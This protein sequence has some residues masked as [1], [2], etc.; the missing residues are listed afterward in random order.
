MVTTLSA[1]SFDA[2]QARVDEYLNVVADARVGGALTAITGNIVTLDSSF[3]SVGI[4]LTANLFEANIA[5]VATLNVNSGFATNLTVEES[6]ITQGDA[7]FQAGLRVP[8]TGIATITQ[9]DLTNTLAGVVTVTSQLEHTLDATVTDAGRANITGGGNGNIF[10]LAAGYRSAEFTVTA[11]EGSNFQSI[12]IHALN[13]GSDI[14]FNEYS[15]L[16]NGPD[17]AE[18]DVVFAAGTF[19]LRA[20]PATA[21]S[22]D[23]TTHVIAHKA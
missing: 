18:F 11:S 21:N 13:T 22:T 8:G 4:A 7:W 6:F 12:K 23:F 9:A 5:D 2:D 20:T 14:V 17:V 3:A 16:S 19:I 10:T 1:E 15:N